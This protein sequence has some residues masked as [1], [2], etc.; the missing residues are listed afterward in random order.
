MTDVYVGWP[1]SVHDARVFRRSP[2]HEHLEANTLEMCPQESYLL[3]DAAYPLRNYL[4]TPFKDNGHLTQKQKT[5]NFKH[6]STR[7][8]VE[9]TFGVFKGKWRR[10]KFIDVVCLEATID[11]IVAACVLHNICQ[12]EEDLEEFMAGDYSID[13]DTIHYSG[14]DKGTP[15]W[16]SNWTPPAP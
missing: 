10:L 15:P 3:G 6:S 1:G 16:P 2:L 14:I 8:K 11:I 9:H 13:A 4:L 12:A 5:Y 7:M